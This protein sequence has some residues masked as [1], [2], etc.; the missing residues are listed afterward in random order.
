MAKKKILWADDDPDDL[1][2]LRQVLQ[3]LDN[4]YEVEEVNNGRE[5]LDYLEAAAKNNNLPCLLILDIN[6][7]VMDGKETLVKIKADQKLENLPIVVF[8]TS[9]SKLDRLFCEKHNVKM[10]TKP[11]SYMNLTEAV[12]KLLTFCGK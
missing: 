4:N 2:L 7:P 1:M 6:M 5:A 9:S 12:K 11:P 8:T 10:I 3:E